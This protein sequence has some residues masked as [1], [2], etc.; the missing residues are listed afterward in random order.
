VRHVTHLRCTEAKAEAFVRCSD[1]GSVGEIS[2]YVDLADEVKR[3][4]LSEDTED[5]TCDLP[6]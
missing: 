4:T 5:R 6:G 2:Q 3:W 1:D